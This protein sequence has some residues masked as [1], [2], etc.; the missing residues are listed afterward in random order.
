MLPQTSHLI[1]E[2]VRT[3][4]RTS[5]SL[6][7]DLDNAYARRIQTHGAIFLAEGSNP[8]LTATARNSLILET[9]VYDGY[10]LS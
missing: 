10:N 1:P 9:Y 5:A 3:K 2:K 8:S 7:N 6:F 4:V